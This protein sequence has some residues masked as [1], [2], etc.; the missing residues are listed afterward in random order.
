M[1]VFHKVPFRLAL[2][3]SHEGDDPINPNLALTPAEMDALR[4]SGKPISVNQLDSQYFDGEPDLHDFNIPL[5]QQR[6]VD[7]N[8]AWETAKTSKEK[9]SKVKASK[10]D[11]NPTKS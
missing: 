7:I 11:I 6:G 5:T 2:C 1:S 10:I 9:L 4:M 8:D 3:E